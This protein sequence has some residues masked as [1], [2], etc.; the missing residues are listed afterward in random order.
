MKLLTKVDLER[1]RRLFCTCDEEHFST[2]DLELCMDFKECKDALSL[3]EGCRECCP[4]FCR[5]WD[6]LLKLSEVS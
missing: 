6:E 1:L 4:G 3:S 5:M 2:E